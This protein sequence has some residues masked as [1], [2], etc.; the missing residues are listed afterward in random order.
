MKYECLIING[1]FIDARSPADL[2]K[3]PWGTNEKPGYVSPAGVHHDVVAIELDREDLDREVQLAAADSQ[4]GRPA[5]VAFLSKI[6]RRLVT[7]DEVAWEKAQRV[8]EAQFL[9]D[10]AMTRRETEFRNRFALQF[11]EI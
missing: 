5:V 10:M 6:D 4:T 3:Q 1:K 2:V 9:F 8:G 7:A 11:G